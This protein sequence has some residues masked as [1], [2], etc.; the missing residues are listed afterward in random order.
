MWI[1]LAACSAADMGQEWQLDRP[2]ILAA[3]AEPAEAAPGDLVQLSSLSWSPDGALGMVWWSCR[4]PDCEGPDPSLVGELLALDWDALG[5]D[6]QSSWRAE[7]QA[8]GV[9]GT[10]PGPPP[11]LAITDDL[12]AGADE[13]ELSLQ[14]E[15]WSGGEVVERAVKSLRAREGADGTNPEILGIEDGGETLTAG[16]ALSLGGAPSLTGIADDAGFDADE[17]AQWR[18]YTD[19]YAASDDAARGGGFFGG[20]SSGETFSWTAGGDSG[21][22]IAVLRDGRGGA[23][24]LALDAVVE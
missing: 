9:L 6:E 22:V 23:D 21:Q 18:W 16:M 14:V 17:T 24:W 13:V 2:R 15:G 1:L 11:Q 5:P 4:S 7:A 3:R 8:A 10:E 20:T 12:L 19:L